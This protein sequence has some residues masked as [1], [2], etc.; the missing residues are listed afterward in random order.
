MYPQGANLLQN[1]TANTSKFDPT[2]KERDLKEQELKDKL[3]ELEDQKWL[4][5]QENERLNFVKEMAE[6]DQGQTFL[7]IL[8]AKTA[9]MKNVK[10]KL[11]KTITNVKIPLCWLIYLGNLWFQMFLW[12]SDY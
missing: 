2:K 11:C 8:Q 6:A 1:Q 5:E 7:D 9:I 12:N 4:L 10:R 3:K